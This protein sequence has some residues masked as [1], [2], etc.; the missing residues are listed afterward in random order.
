M[1]SH[2]PVFGKSFAK[3]RNNIKNRKY[4]A[5]NNL[6]GSVLLMNI[7][8]H[9]FASRIVRLDLTGAKL[10]KKYETAAKIG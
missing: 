6:Y 8:Q 3:I 1:R 2:S 4:F 7:G 5:E 9:G 10:R